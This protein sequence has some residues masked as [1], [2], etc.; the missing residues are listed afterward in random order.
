MNVNVSSFLLQEKPKEAKEIPEKSVTESEEAS[1]LT[2]Q[3]ANGLV[4]T[5]GTANLDLEAE[6]SQDLSSKVETVEPNAPEGDAHPETGTGTAS[7]RRNISSFLC[8]FF[9]LDHVLSL[10]LRCISATSS[11]LH[12]G[13]GTSSCSLS[14]LF[15]TKRER[16]CSDCRE[17]RRKGEQSSY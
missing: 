1:D 7:H 11:G 9:L 15:L 4:Q 16:R 17:E 8:T 5:D 2:P 6:D 14:G 10:I 3:T 12:L 13:S